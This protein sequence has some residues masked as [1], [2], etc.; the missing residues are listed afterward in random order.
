[1]ERRP[2]REGAAGHC[3]PHSRPTE[4]L[5][6]AVVQMPVKAV[7]AHALTLL[8]SPAP[9]SKVRWLRAAP[10]VSAELGPWLVPT[11]SS[12]SAPCPAARALPLSRLAALSP[13]AA[14]RGSLSSSP[15]FSSSPLSHSRVPRTAPARAASP[16]PAPPGR[17]AHEGAALAPAGPPVWGQPAAPSAD[18]SALRGRRAVTPPSWPWGTRGFRAMANAHLRAVTGRKCYKARC[19]VSSRRHGDHALRRQEPL[20]VLA[21]HAVSYPFTPR[22]WAPRSSP[23]QLGAF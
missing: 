7:P 2:N 22:S 11:G 21:P 1:M 12:Q 10:G 8:I 20:E 15:S 5:R 3:S 4:H 18:S 17:A 23:F 9:L 16:E 14:A 6:G 13:H 19:L